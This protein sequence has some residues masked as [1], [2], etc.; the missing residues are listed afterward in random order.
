MTTTTKTAAL[1][2]PRLSSSSS[3]SILP[4]SAAETA[5]ERG[6]FFADGY[7]RAAPA[8]IPG[9]KCIHR[10]N[11]VLPLHRQHHRLHHHH[12]PLLQIV[13]SAP[14]LPTRLQYRPLRRRPT[15]IVNTHPDA[16]K[17]REAILNHGVVDERA[18]RARE[19]ASPARR[20]VPEP[21]GSARGISARTKRRTTTILVT[22]VVWRVRIFG[23]GCWGTSASGFDRCSL[24]ISRSWRSFMRAISSLIQRRS[25]RSLRRSSTP[26]AVQIWFQNRRHRRKETKKRQRAE[27]KGNS[28]RQGSNGS[29]AWRPYDEEA[30][31]T[32]VEGHYLLQRAIQI[33]KVNGCEVIEEEDDDNDDDNYKSSGGSGAGGTSQQLLKLRCSAHSHTFL[34]SPRLIRPWFE[35]WEGCPLCLLQTV[36]SDASRS[37][38]TRARRPGLWDAST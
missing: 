8:C 17:Q 11:C 37:E 20:S 30:E 31:T 10:L 28:S 33:A 27:E 38:G 6:V 34:C 15:S 18:K 3:P 36:C 12:R 22:M 14:T 9:L 16:A 21:R 23:G 2:P 24:R 35:K 26:H 1:R 4:Q 5:C 19:V 32:D 25:L 13:G 29:N 7:P